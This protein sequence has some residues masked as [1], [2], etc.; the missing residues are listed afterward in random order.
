MKESSPSISNSGVYRE[1]G[2]LF[3]NHTTENPQG[4][5]RGCFQYS[6]TLTSLALDSWTSVSKLVVSH[7]SKA[8]RSTQSVA[9]RC[10]ETSLMK[11]CNV[12]SQRSSFW[13]TRTATSWWRRILARSIHQSPT[14]TVCE[15]ETICFCTSFDTLLFE[16]LSFTSLRMFLG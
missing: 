15:R 2:A 6:L 3:E 12:T 9:I 5:L 8:L 14:F 16:D 10:V 1:S 11:W 4:R 13:L 7:C